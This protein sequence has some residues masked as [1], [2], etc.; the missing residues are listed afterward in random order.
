[1]ISRPNGRPKCVNAVTTCANHISSY[2]H[3]LNSVRSVLTATSNLYDADLAPRISL[4]LVTKN[5]LNKER[6]FHLKL[7]IKYHLYH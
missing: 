5:E 1:M 7:S 6:L 2:I 3:L 4:F